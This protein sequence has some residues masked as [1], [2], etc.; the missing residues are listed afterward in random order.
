[1]ARKYPFGQCR[2]AIETALSKEIAC[3]IIIAQDIS[4]E[5][6]HT[7]HRFRIVTQ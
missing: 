4:I 1:M 7:Q 5:L 2:Y 6:V 3:C